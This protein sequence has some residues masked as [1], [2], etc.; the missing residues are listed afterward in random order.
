MA[1]GVQLATAYVNIEASTKGLGKQITKALGKVDTSG[2][3]TKSGR[4]WVKGFDKATSGISLGAVAGVAAKAT[5]LLVSGLG[6]YMNAAVEAS[7]ST[8]KFKSTLD[9]A[10]VDTATI[11]RLTK[12]TQ[13][14][15]DATVYDLADIRNVTAQLAANGVKDYDRLAEAAGNLNAVAGGNAETFKSVGMV[16]TQTAGQGKLTTENF[17]Q[18]SDAIPGASG[19]IQQALKKMGAYTSGNFRDA[20]EKGEISAEEF[21]QALMDLGM[22][23][24]AVEAAK[25]TKT[26]EG[27]VGNWDAAIQKLI[28]KG[29]DAV[30]PAFTKALGGATD[31]VSDFTDDISDNLDD[32]QKRFSKAADSLLEGNLAQAIGDVFDLD[33]GVVRSLNEAF[34]SL[35]DGFQSI[36]DALADVSPGLGAT[37]GAFGLFADTLKTISPLLPAIADLVT[38]FASLPEPVQIAAVGLVAFHKPLGAII[39]VAKGAG[40]MFKGIVDGIAGIGDKASDSTGKVSRLSGSLGGFN[41][42]GVAMSAALGIAT[43]AIAA[44]GDEMSSNKAIADDFKQSMLEGAD[45]VDQFWNNVRSGESGDIGF[46]SEFASGFKSSDISGLLKQTGADFDDFKQAVMGSGDAL[47]RVMQ[48]AGADVGGTTGIITT[49]IESITDLL[50]GNMVGGVSKFFQIGDATALLQQVDN[51]RESY[52]LAVAQMVEFGNTQQSIASGMSDARNAFSELG[53][54]LKAN[55]DSLANNG[56]L[57]DQSTAAI[58]RANDKLWESVAAQLAYGQSTGEMDE[59]VQQAKNSVQQMRDSLISTLTQQGMS[60]EA[61]AAYADSLG[62]IPA[63]VSTRF[64]ADTLASQGMIDAYLDR[65]GATPDQKATVMEAL[66][67]QAGGNIDNLNMKMSSIPKQVQSI[68]TADNIDA[69]GK[70]EDSKRRLDEY[71]AKRPKAVLDADNAQALN[72]TSAAQKGIDQFG[73]CRVKAT[74]DVQDNASSKLTGILGQLGKIASQ[75]WTGVV[76]VVTGGGKAYG[77]LIDGG[78]VTG[79]GSRVSDTA[80]ITPLSAGE[81]VIRAKSASRIGYTTLDRLNRTGTL[82]DTV[83]APSSV[84]KTGRT[85]VAGYADERVVALLQRILLELEAGQRIELDG[86]EMGRTVRR[87]ANA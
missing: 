59:A 11:D 18:L 30:K 14:Y 26:F 71:G 20:M 73:N 6:K 72:K 22:T 84:R 60:A 17:N 86:R 9:F 34:D 66:T 44:V 8:D 24:A 77:G 36:G 65:I 45:A 56:Q 68:L 54:T 83:T 12:S 42:A 1:D 5:E 29:L 76:S 15:A 87:Y 25:S 33:P 61:A 31:I 19:K 78:K 69:V 46:I 35:G 38:L 21:N 47:N 80:Q 55:G 27:A 48:Q 32:L 49:G 85:A 79:P 7:D 10:G 74:V 3:G 67:A 37:N 40:G 57:T 13:A 28:T 62:L 41:P 39:N 81:Y 43:A 75:V 82:P 52:K 58:Q 53:T 64:T 4:A 2:Q 63:N 23:D 16:L 51:L 50:S 70:T